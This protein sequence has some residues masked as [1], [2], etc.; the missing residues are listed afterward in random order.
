MLK[1]FVSSICILCLLCACSGGTSGKEA[2]SGMDVKSAAQSLVKDLNLTDTT[3]EVE[4]RVVQGLFFFEDGVVTA[5]DVYLANDKSA[6]IVG[7][8]KTTN[9]ESCE[10]SI[11]TYLSTT[12][13]QMQS[14]FPEEVFKVDNALV[15][16]NG[17][18]TV[19]LIICK[20]METAKTKAEAILKG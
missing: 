10:N 2:S 4:D 8:F 18:D 17:S 11:K 12:K 14:Y 3:A 9:I 15:Q 20:D 16:D 1:K 5:S 19:I 6:D 7:V 13:Q